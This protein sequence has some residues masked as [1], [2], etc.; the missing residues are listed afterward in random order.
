MNI[1]NDIQCKICWTNN[2]FSSND[3]R[4]I[5]LMVVLT[6]IAL[7]ICY[8]TVLWYAIRTRFVPE[9]TADVI[10]HKND[11]FNHE[12]ESHEDYIQARTTTQDWVV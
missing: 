6:S 10:V 2:G 12:E 5:I 4:S 3:R 8:V 11:A 9:K 1:T 7:I